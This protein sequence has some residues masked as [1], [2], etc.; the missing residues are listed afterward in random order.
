MPKPA[1]A[2]TDWHRQIYASEPPCGVG[3]W[4]TADRMKVVKLKHISE[5]HLMRLTR[6]V[7]LKPQHFSKRDEV[8]REIKRRNPFNP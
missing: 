2:P 3:Q 6:F 4:R 1:A 8:F 7:L 5:Q